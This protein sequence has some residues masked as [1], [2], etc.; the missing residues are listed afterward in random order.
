MIPDLCSPV[1]TLTLDW[2]DADLDV[3]EATER[4]AKIAAQLMAELKPGDEIKMQS[5]AGVRLVPG[6]QRFDPALAE[7]IL[8]AELLALISR[9]TAS[10]KMAS[11][12]V[13]SG[14][15]PPALYD[16]CRKPAGDPYLKRL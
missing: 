4:K 11:A 16:Q 15:L 7:E 1:T 9:T 10:A 3:K 8:P 13:S 14:I 12:L 6:V 2:L 5:G